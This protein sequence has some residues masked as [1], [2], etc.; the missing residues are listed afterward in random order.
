MARS[1]RAKAFV[2]LWPLL[3]L[4]ASGSWAADSLHI[5][6]VGM[7]SL[8]GSRALAAF[9]LNGRAYSLAGSGGRLV[10]L[11]VTDPAGPSACGDLSLP[12]TIFDIAVQGTTAFL[13]MGSQVV[14]VDVADPGNP[15]FLGRL[16]LPDSVQRLSADVGRLYLAAGA[17]GVAV[18]N[19]SDPARMSL[20]GTCRTP[21]RA[22][23]VAI[24]GSLCYALDDS[25]GLVKIDASL[26]SNPSIISQCSVP[27]S[28]VAVE[29]A[30]GAA[31]VASRYSD[32][33]SS[34]SVVDLDSMSLLETINVPDRLEDV[35]CCRGFLIAATGQAGVH[36]YDITDPRDLGEAGYCQTVGSALRA[37]VLDSVALLGDT[38]G[39]MTLRLSG[40]RHLPEAGHAG[41]GGDFTDLAISGSLAY[42]A[43]ATFGLRMFDI[44]DP[45]HPVEIGG[46]DTP[47]EPRQVVLQEGR[48]YLADGT[49]GVRIYDLSDP[50]HP[51]LLG[52][53]DTPGTANG[54]AVVGTKA[55]VA[56]GDSGLSAYDI[57]DPTNPWLWIR[58]NIEIDGFHARKC[59]AYS[60]VNGTWI[61]LTGANAALAT[62]RI[63][64]GVNLA[65]Y[66]NV[67]ASGHRIA[68]IGQYMFVVTDDEFLWCMKPTE[69][70]PATLRYSVP[71]ASGRGRAFA[72]SD[73]L[74]FTANGEEGFQA[75]VFKTTRKGVTTYGVGHLHTP[76]QAQA[77]ALAG[78]HV[79]LADG[80]GGL[81][82]VDIS[83]LSRIRQDGWYQHPLSAYGLAAE[84]DRLYVCDPGSGL[85][86]LDASDPA[87][88]RELGYCPLP[89]PAFGVAAGGGHAYV[90][91]GAWGLRTV[92]VADPAR[93]FITGAFDTTGFFY[94]VC[95]RETL[96]FAAA[97]SSGLLV[98]GVSDPAHPRLMGRYDTP[99]SALGVSLQGDTAL[100]ADGGA[101]LQMLDVSDPSQPEHLASYAAS[102][103]A[104][105]VEAWGRF[106]L[107]ADGRAG[108]SV[109]DIGQ[110]G[111]PTLVSQLYT[112][113]YARQISVHD[114]ICYL[115]C[116][117]SGLLAINLA[118]PTVPE[119]VGWYRTDNHIW[120]NTGLGPYQA[121]TDGDASVRIVQGYG[122]GRRPPP[123][124]SRWLR[125]YPNPFGRE[126]RIE[127]LLERDCWVKTSVYN[128]AGQ[129]VEVLADRAVQAGL[130]NLSWPAVQSR[131]ASGVYL[132]RVQAGNLDSVVRLI[133]VR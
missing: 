30:G 9:I 105:W 8:G 75:Q 131:Q 126:A 92:S 42:V 6:T 21:E 3:W 106:A 18:V 101:G 77:V 44:S 12:G 70:N 35:S 63:R 60:V 23:D 87:L 15:S 73:S 111:A 37:A 112:G 133:L 109:L 27:D 56:D 78:T 108:L 110:A 89:G 25:A 99:G 71:I 66:M 113:G 43:D 2:L 47:G 26:P 90:A 83:Q 114:S 82:S 107:V 64:H 79:W 41:E 102:D 61:S 128:I 39:V 28:A 125:V 32:W 67:G 100:V 127:L 53:F 11:D 94:S 19:A 65:G 1:L 31:F 130:H 96:A 22:V 7:W 76:G 98:I 119:Q 123:D 72:R 84:G 97:E 50:V 132:L 4:L 10:V 5:R 91:N 16:A 33:Y 34:I 20:L 103:C 14:A 17:S 121:I 62:V 51:G 122:L 95:L 120:G 69:R 93:P 46:L 68:I 85:R 86:I 36:V 57:S 88:I 129:L 59:A 115:S 81:R 38:R 117:D 124:Y 29:L 40:L 49:A 118:D 80:P 116:S 13:A 45:G 54:L 104:N 48:L 58:F 24:H 74:L 55:Y 52:W